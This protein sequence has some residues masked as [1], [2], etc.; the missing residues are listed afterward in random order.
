VLV[1]SIPLD[2]ILS[3]NVPAYAI[4]LVQAGLGDRE[5]MLTS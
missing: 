3:A 5:A 2:P 4:A 1:S